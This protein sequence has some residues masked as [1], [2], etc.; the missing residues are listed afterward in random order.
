MQTVPDSGKEKGGG[1]AARDLEREA[2][3]YLEDADLARPRYGRS[4]IRSSGGS[5]E[6]V[7]EIR[8]KLHVQI[9]LTHTNARKHKRT[10]TNTIHS[11]V[12]VKGKRRRE[13]EMRDFQNK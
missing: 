5:I 11:G 1:A 10:N 2:K 13:E 12:S 3:L 9:K 4:G 8:N 7:T 6:K